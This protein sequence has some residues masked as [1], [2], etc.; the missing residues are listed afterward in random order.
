MA[1]EKCFRVPAVLDEFVVVRKLFS[2]SH[3]DYALLR[4]PHCGQHFLH[5]FDERVD[6]DGG[7]DQMWSLYIALTDEE[8]KAIDALPDAECAEGLHNDTLHQMGIGN[9]AI[10]KGPNHQW[11]GN[12][13]QL[14][15][16]A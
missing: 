16:P 3:L 12:R 8:V 1:C 7:D 11:R 10:V 2:S 15:W 14:P 9:P 13:L 5:T 4:C 6:W